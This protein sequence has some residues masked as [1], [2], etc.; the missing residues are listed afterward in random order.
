[1]FHKFTGC[2]KLIPL[3]LNCLNLNV[4]RLLPKFNLIYLTSV[5]KYKTF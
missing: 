3:I 5:N 4:N 2:L 1:M